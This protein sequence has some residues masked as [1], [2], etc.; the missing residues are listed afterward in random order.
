MNPKT[1]L[2]ILLL[3]LILQPFLWQEFRLSRLWWSGTWI[4]VERGQG[5]SPT[6]ATWQVDTGY[7]F[8]DLWVKGPGES[9]V[10]W[11]ANRDDFPVSCWIY[12]DKASAEPRFLCYQPISVYMSSCNM[13]KG[14]YLVEN[15]A[16]QPVVTN[17][18]SKF[19]RD[20]LG[21]FGSDSFGRY[22][23]YFSSSFY[24][25]HNPQELFEDVESW[26]SKPQLEAW[27]KGLAS[28]PEA[29][30]RQPFP[31]SPS[32]PGELVNA[33]VRAGR[34]T[35]T[36]APMFRPEDQAVEIKLVREGDA[37]KVDDPL[38]DWTGQFTTATRQRWPRL[39]LA[40]DIAYDNV[41]R[42][43]KAVRIHPNLLEAASD[44]VTP[45]HQAAKAGSLKVIAYLLDKGI[46]LEATDRFRRTP[47]HEAVRKPAALTALLD[48]GAKLDHEDD[49]GR[50]PLHWAC[51]GLE[52]ESVRILLAHGARQDRTLLHVVMNRDHTV[53]P[54]DPEA[55]LA[56]AKILVDRGADVTAKDAEG[57]TPVDLA[58]ESGLKAAVQH[59]EQR[60]RTR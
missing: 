21:V 24:D 37:W 1:R 39:G 52:V 25:A 15:G 19:L 33:R 35:L 9:K 27:R 30:R 3:L 57:H 23:G 7:N 50:T 44:G 46:P 47:L 49:K 56:L 2:A 31:V 17:P 40:E 41:E 14:V 58:R 29:Q 59:M 20:P 10:F 28:M 8:E 32:V 12:Q 11:S 45:L 36:V 34:A 4:R 38:I 53:N 22:S 6:G 16:C 18:L 54:G 55:A 60:G 13:R 51:W 26:L 43:E 48:R 42:L 5:T